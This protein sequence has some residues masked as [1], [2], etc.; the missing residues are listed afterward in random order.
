MGVGFSELIVIF[1][2]LLVLGSL[3]TGIVLWTTSGS[4][5]SSEMSC[6]ACGYAVRGLTQ[7]NCPECGVDLRE[8]G[9]RV[10]QSAGRRTTGMILAFGSVGI[11]I[12]L[13]LLMGFLFLSSDASVPVPASHTLPAPSAA[14]TPSQPSNQPDTATQGPAANASDSVIEHAN[15]SK[16]IINPDGSSITTHPDGSTTLIQLDGTTKEFDPN[17]VEIQ[18]PETDGAQTP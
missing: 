1:I 8:A 5:K 18:T 11:L 14:P 12:L 2:L 4:G 7:L 9:I 13:V 10:Q 17:G 6:G 15:G 3:L 16:T